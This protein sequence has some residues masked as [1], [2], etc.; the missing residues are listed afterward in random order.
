LRTG[1][2]LPGRPSRD[3]HSGLIKAHQGFI[4]TLIETNP[5]LTLDEIRDALAARGVMKSGGAS[6]SIDQTKKS[7]Y[8]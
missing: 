8:K 6:T 5:D 7:F 1:K 2:V 3:P 4:R